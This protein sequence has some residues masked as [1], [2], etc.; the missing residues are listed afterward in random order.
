MPALVYRHKYLAGPYYKSRQQNLEII[1][2]TV[3]PASGE[4]RHA[5]T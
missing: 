2:K 5:N 4:P 3:D 1:P